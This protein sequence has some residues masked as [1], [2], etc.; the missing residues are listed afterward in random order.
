[1]RRKSYILALS[2]VLLLSVSACDAIG[3]A[4]GSTKPGGAA[5][6]AAPGPTNA[7]E[8][9]A[10]PPDTAPPDTAPPPTTTPSGEEES[11][12]SVPMFIGLILFAILLVGIL[13]GRSRRQR[14]PVAAPPT[15]A[16]R[17]GFID[18][19]RDGYSEARWLLD[20]FTDELAI[21]RGNALFDGSTAPEDSPGTALASSWA[22]LDERMREA[23]DQLYRAEAAAPD[24]NTASAVRAAIVALNGTRSALDSRAEARFNTRHT[25]SQFDLAEA[26]ERERIASSALA[27]NKQTLSDALLALS[28]LL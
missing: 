24:Q 9:T 22:Q 15:A 13:I 1:M 20:A 21:W 4:I 25:Q 5:T 7:P 17:K 28:T 19:A 26:G 6:S 23:T 3:S 16:G 10:A 12:K 14:T 2:A 11:G 18:F 27:E 8:P